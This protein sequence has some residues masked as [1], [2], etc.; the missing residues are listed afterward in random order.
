MTTVGGIKGKNSNNDDVNAKLRL[1]DV[2][3]SICRD[4]LCGNGGVCTRKKCDC[5]HKGEGKFE[6]SVG[7]TVLM[8]ERN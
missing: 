2:N 3:E 7:E 5:S 6:L 4:K 8:V 1:V